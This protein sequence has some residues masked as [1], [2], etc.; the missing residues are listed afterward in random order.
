MPE[1]YDK[2]ADRVAFRDG[3]KPSDAYLFLCTSEMVRL[4]Q[5]NS[6]ARYT[7]LANCGSTPTP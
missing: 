6:I 2:A 7:D 3:M 4:P 1:P 5:I